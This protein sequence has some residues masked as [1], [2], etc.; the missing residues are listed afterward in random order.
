LL[1]FIFIAVYLTLEPIA[2]VYIVIAGSAAAFCPRPFPKHPHQPTKQQR[3]DHQYHIRIQYLLHILG[4]HSQVAD[5][6][7]DSG[8]GNPGKPWLPDFSLYMQFTAE[9][10]G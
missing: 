1:L 2:A 6:L 4:A 3:K 10:H 9:F 7:Q 8:F 5:T